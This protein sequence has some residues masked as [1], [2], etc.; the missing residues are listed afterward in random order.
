[1]SENARSYMGHLWIQREDNVY[2]ISLNEDAIDDFENIESV[3]L[4]RENEE[5]EEDIVCGT[6]E[7]DNG[8]LDIFSPVTGVVIEVNSAVIEDPSLIQEDPQG[9]GWLIK[10]ESS[11]D[12]FEDEVLEQDAIEE[13]EYNCEE[14]LEEGEEMEWEESLLIPER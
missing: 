4:P 5:I 3:D 13:E 8:P 1:M 12:V 14:V 2:T 7:T 11:E 10:V 6:I 9:D